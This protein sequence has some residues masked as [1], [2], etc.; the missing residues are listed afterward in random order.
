MFRKEVLVMSLKTPF[1]TLRRKIVKAG[2]GEDS[3]PVAELDRMVYDRYVKGD[4]TVEQYNVLC[5]MLETSF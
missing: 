4:I 3:T 2:D 1:D 5:Y